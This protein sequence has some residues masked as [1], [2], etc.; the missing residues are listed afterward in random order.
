MRQEGVLCVHLPCHASRLCVCVPCVEGPL[1]KSTVESAVAGPE[2]RG[3]CYSSCAWWGGKQGFQRLWGMT[4]IG[5]QSFL[6]S[7]NFQAS[8]GP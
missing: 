8:I 6:P 5:D 4:I 2:V 3:F 7:Q 1:G